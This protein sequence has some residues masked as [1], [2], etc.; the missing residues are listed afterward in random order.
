MSETKPSWSVPVALSDI[1][2]GGRH[3]DLAPDDGTRAELAKLAGLRA[4]PRLDATFDVSRDGAHGLRVTGHVEA[5]VGQNCVVTLEPMENKVEETVD[6]VFVPARELSA[7]ENASA[8]D[9]VDPDAPE[10][11]AGDR[12][13]LGKIATEFL[14]L[15][16]DPYP[17]KPGATFE[18][19][20]VDDD[21]TH[22]F[23][24]LAALKKGEGGHEG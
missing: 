12:V 4:L 3:Y 5:L 23:A 21:G 22:P 11:L 18:P 14:L 13:D 9:V 16:I 20:P 19:L 1:P 2:E 6:L 17:R 10:P 24:A 8:G 15:G 7:E